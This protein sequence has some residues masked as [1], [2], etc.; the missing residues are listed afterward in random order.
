MRTVKVNWREVSELS[1]RTLNN[2]EEFERAR[3]N[4][5]SIINTIPQCWKGTDSETH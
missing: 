2:Y 5:Q 4:Y 3:E 1:K